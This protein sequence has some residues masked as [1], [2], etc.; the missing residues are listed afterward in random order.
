MSA[1]ELSLDDPARH[2][3]ARDLL[4]ADHAL[5][6]RQNLSW[7]SRRYGFE[8]ALSHEPA[9]RHDLTAL[10]P[11]DDPLMRLPTWKRWVTL[12]RLATVARDEA[13]RQRIRTALGFRLL[14]R[15]PDLS[16]L[17]PILA[18][19][20]D[21][22]DEDTYTA[23]IARF[24]AL[25]ASDRIIIDVAIAT[26]GLPTLDVIFPYLAGPHL[27][28]RLADLDAQFHPPGRILVL[29][30]APLSSADADR[31]AGDDRI[32][33][34][35]AHELAAHLNAPY[36]LILEPIVALRPETLFTFADAARA[37][38]AWQLIYAD[39]DR[40]SG[41]DRHAP[42][43]KP[44]FSPELN[45][46]MAYLGA[47]V[48]VAT[49]A[50]TAPP[51]I[52]LSTWAAT[53][54]AGLEA[55]TIGRIPR[56]LFHGDVAIPEA[57]RL[58]YP[59]P[60]LPEPS[61]AIIIPTRNHAGLLAT[62]VDSIR[63]KSDYP[64]EKLGFVIIDNGSDEPNALELLD[65]LA[66]EPGVTLLR[67]P[68][69][70][71]Y[72]RLNN[73]AAA[74]ATA[75]ILVFLNNDTEVCDPA[76]LRALAGW[77]ATPGIGV[78]GPKLLYPDHTI[79]HAGV[80]LG[81]G[82]VAGHSFVGL[83]SDNPGYIGL[84][85]V[86]RE[87]AALTGACIALS[88]ALFEQIGGFDEHL[89]IAF[90]DTALCCEALRRGNRN[91]YL[92]ETT[93][94]HHESKSRGFDDTPEKLER[95]RAECSYVRLEYKSLFDQ[96]PYYSPNLGLERQYQPAIPRVRRP[97]HRHRRAVD[98]HPRILIL[99][100]V[101]ATGHGVPVVIKQ[102]AD[103]LAAQGWTVFV[104][105]PLRANEIVY[106]GCQR[107]YLD[108]PVEAQSF[109]Y[110]AD[111]DAV[112]IHT[113][114]YFAML[115]NMSD[116][117]LRVI[118]D[119]GEPPPA[120]FPD[121]RAREIID[122]EKQFSYRLADLVLT[123]T[124]TVKDEIGYDRAEVAGLGNS[125]LAIWDESL[126]ARRD[127]IRA[128]LGLTDKI[129]V[130]NVCRFHLAERRYKGID[131]YIALDRAAAADPSLAGRVVFILCGKGS[132]ADRD[133][134]VS[135]GLT[136]HASV[137]DAALIEL[138]VAADLYVNFSKWEGFNLGIAQ[139]LAMG[140]EVVA[141]DIPAHRQFPI[142][143]SDDPAHRLASLTAA[144]ERHRAGRTRL[145]VLLPWEP[146]LVWLRD[147]LAALCG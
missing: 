80:V 18:L 23:W 1:T 110:A 3:A 91:L 121:H 105:G 17:A 89:Q 64:A 139:A 21:V 26:A 84:A 138:Y 120:W 53:L 135:A 100:D 38:P 35:P 39:E 43:F 20:S 97:W 52:P 123:N 25:S 47:C 54:A 31:V 41:R 22:V 113:I 95:F 57:P 118:F 104:G 15:Q 73:I 77:T 48:C 65:R 36:A 143:T 112:I 79:Q 55:A 119:H 60:G 70:F 4:L 107:V 51:A 117:P 124:S 72:A 131:D 40:R 144:I 133:E 74:A 81:I 114:P 29:T 59:E 10:G 111:V 116:A 2:R 127:D 5:V 37:N 46:R 30:D 19:D 102:H 122:G 6:H 142:A 13:A 99:S 68:A 136:V 98:P 66:R 28:N 94:I 50:I 109:A 14:G 134:M 85:S 27:A 75:E 101:H 92:G 62:C 93:V 67:D 146:L 147:R 9:P 34:V 45:R 49:R 11:P 106:E 71:N 58:A 103:Y 115:R 16:A 12:L 7:L 24:D 129:V 90:N 8:Q 132:E 78:V 44:V 108:G 82:G 128:R 63:E 130:L 56:V 42:I 145:A 69:P 86:T 32:I 76:W 83:A 126:A 88:R 137:T 125:H 33:V 96:D 140:L 61:V 141:S 87:A